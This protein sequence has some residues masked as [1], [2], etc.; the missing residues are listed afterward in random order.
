M[1]GRDPSNPCLRQRDETSEFVP[2]EKGWDSDLDQSWLFH[3][4]LET[5]QERIRVLREER[6]RIL[7]L[8]MQG[9]EPEREEKGKTPDAASFSLTLQSSFVS[10]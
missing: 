5:K 8:C 3:L 2:K 1:E 9:L 7:Y 10:S 6:K 4:R